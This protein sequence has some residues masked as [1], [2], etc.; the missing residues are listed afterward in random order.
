MLRVRV[1]CHG[2]LYDQRNPDSGPIPSD[3]ISMRLVSSKTGTHGV[4]LLVV[5]AN[6]AASRQLAEPDGSARL[7]EL[8]SH[9]VCASELFESRFRRWA[10]L[11]SV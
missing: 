1:C 10:Q 5:L 6:L 11:N 3:S 7:L 2:S 9:M 4:K 8:R